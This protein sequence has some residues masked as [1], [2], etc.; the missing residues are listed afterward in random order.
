MGKVQSK[1]GECYVFDAHLNPVEHT[2]ESRKLQKMPLTSSTA[3]KF[4]SELSLSLC[5]V[6]ECKS[7]DKH[8]LKGRLL[9]VLKIVFMN[10]LV[11]LPPKDCS[12]HG[13]GEE[14]QLEKAEE[15]KSEK[16]ERRNNLKGIQTENS[17]FTFT[18]YDFNGSGKVSKDDVE[19]VVGRTISEALEK[20]LNFSATNHTIQVHLAITPESESKHKSKSDQTEREGTN[21]SKEKVSLKH[22]CD[23]NATH[24][25]FTPGKSNRKKYY[26]QFEKKISD[27]PRQSRSP[28]MQNQKS[29]RKLSLADD[30]YPTNVNE[31]VLPEK[32]HK[33]RHYSSA[34]RNIPECLNHRSHYLDLAG[35]EN[36]TSKFA[37]YTT[38]ACLS[39]HECPG[40]SFQRTNLSRCHK[41]RERKMH[42]RRKSYSKETH[43]FNVDASPHLFRQNKD[44]RCDPLETN[45]DLSDEAK[46]KFN[47]EHPRRSKS[48]DVHKNNEYL[49]HNSPKPKCQNSAESISPNHY[50][51]RKHK[52]QEKESQWNKLRKHLEKDFNTKCRKEN[53]KFIALQEKDK[54]EHHHVHEHIHHH[55]H[56]YVDS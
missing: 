14:N 9:Q 52:E 56:H 13:D 1:Q 31:T 46:E 36:Y 35:I 15:E 39:V 37:T 55:Y 2:D 28:R 16:E 47:W 8:P 32:S 41:E 51:C 7:P 44:H 33:N 17:E 26:N 24:P 48:H 20:S 30:R 3:S 38:N 23:A 21:S 5:H 54:C 49:R 40:E 29:R 10:C 27:L 42:H 6:D 45:F 18:L 22:Y 12:E 4:C 34:C 25:P 11:Y 43:P 50:C 19:R 53:L